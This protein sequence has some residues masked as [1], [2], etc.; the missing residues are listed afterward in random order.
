MNPALSV[1]FFTVLSGAGYGLFMVL[2]IAGLFP[3]LVATQ[4]GVISCITALCLVT[5]GLL[6]STLHLANPKNAWRAFSRFRTSWLSREGV[7]AIIFYLPAFLYLSAWWFGASHNSVWL[8]LS[9]LIFALALATVFS[10][11]MIYA[12]L[13]TIRQ[14]N[15]AL[16]PANYI[17]LALMQGILLLL[18]IKAKTDANLLEPYLMAALLLMVLALLMKLIY[19][20]WIDNTTGASIQTATGFT[21]D[22]VHLLDA[23]HTAGTFLTTE[24]NYQVSHRLLMLLRGVSLLLAFIVPLLLAIMMINQTLSY[25]SGTTA[26]VLFSLVGLLLERW[27]FFSEA[28]HVVNLYHGTQHV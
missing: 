8:G 2:A 5:A 12:C 15:T 24:F 22:R 16:T 28:R 7:L 20:G 26:A 1:I 10:T 6:S 18:L 4:T 25:A 23:G 21:R 9:L 13:K 3:G 14:W 17:L 19:Y 11:G 27:L